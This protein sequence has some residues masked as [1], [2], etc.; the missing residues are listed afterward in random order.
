MFFK[1]S[2]SL[3]KK[4][5][6]EVT[7]NLIA[8]QWAKVKPDIPAFQNHPP[9]WKT[10]YITI[11]CWSRLPAAV[12][13]AIS[14]PLWLLQS[15][16]CCPFPSGSKENTACL[17]LL[18]PLSCCPP[19]KVK[20]LCWKL[21]LTTLKFIWFYNCIEHSQQWTLSMTYWPFHKYTFMYT[22]ACHLWWIKQVL[23]R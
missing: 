21:Q 14:F 7:L 5:Q 16:G 18:I 13:S 9:E 15:Q 17:P 11:P 6:S 2:Y 4:L 8:S 22:C 10:R 19:Y 23:N 3:A 20:N 12:L 1:I